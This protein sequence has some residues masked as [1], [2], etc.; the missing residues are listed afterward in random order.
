MQGK[1]VKGFSWPE[2]QAAQRTDAVPH[3]LQDELEKLGGDYSIADKPFATYVV[4][5]GRLI[6]GQNPGS[7]RAVAEA[8]VNRLEGAL[9]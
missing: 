6:T 9:A 3:S 7:A 1:R 8:V 2:E 5:D 4:A